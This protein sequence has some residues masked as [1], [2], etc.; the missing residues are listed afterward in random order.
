MTSDVKISVRDDNA[1]EVV[2]N[3]PTAGNALTP[4]MALAIGAALQ[5]LPAETR[6]VVLRAEGPDFCTGRS[7]A[8][9]PA[10][11]RAT[12]LDLRRVVADPVLDFYA[13]LRHLPVPLISVVRGRAAGVGCALAGLADVAIAADTAVFSVPEMNH[14]IA[15]TLV[16]TALAD[17]LP[18]AAL[19]RLVLTRDAVSA[20]EA[21][22]LG[23]IGM[24]VPEADLE[25]ETDRIV[26]QLL[27]NSVPVVRGIKAFLTTSPE[28]SFT[29]RREQAALIN[30]TV[31]AERYR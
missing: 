22:S 15:P 21:K 2:L 7:S 16:M 13:L 20:A 29:A 23:L 11:T 19:A 5:A 24:V 28:M 12:A 8:M 9:P 27:K 1:V 10:G 25:R 6:V 31:A 14:D 18:R 4:E 17:R 3:R 30:A 26:G